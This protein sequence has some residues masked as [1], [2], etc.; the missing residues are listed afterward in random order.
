MST[1]WVDASWLD[2][3]LDEH[4]DELI[5]C[6]H[7]LHAHPELSNQ[8]VRTTALIV[9]RLARAGL[10]PRVL[11]TGTG[12]LCDLGTGDSASRDRADRC[13][14]L[15]ADIDG[16]AMD[17][18]KSVGHRSTVAGVAHGCGHDL[19]TTVVLG[20]G[21][22]LAHHLDRGAASGRVRLIFEPSEEMLPGG[23]HDVIAEGG[24]DD[25]DAI[26]GFHADPRID[27][28][29]IGL[30]VGA[31]TSAADDLEV[32]LHGPGGHTARPHLTVDLVALAGRIAAEL[33]ALVASRAE[34]SVVFGAIRAGEAPNVVPTTAVLRGSVRTPEVDTWDR[35]EA[36]VRAALHELI[37][38]PRATC[39]VAYRRGVP[40][41][42]NTAAET[43]LMAE[44]VEAVLGADHLVEPPRS[45]GG[46]TFAWYQQRVGGCYARL[47]VHDPAD[48]VHLDLHSGAFDVDDR[49]I[50]TGIRVLVTTALAAL[51]RVDV[52]G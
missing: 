43:A 29:T 5:A 34:L 8:E 6:R 12:V 31:L 23:A 17:D 15:R 44:A 52:E 26:F 50:E 21:L 14:A 20:A 32:T 4:L 9:E 19:H 13:V 22:A 27:V 7:H 18:T 33:P 10:G 38:D 48:P 2:D 28:G 35:A 47:G 42:V 11:R 40:P 16:L 51:R 36:V 25:V 37:D 45:A 41:V 24:L 30:R 46:D 3:F 49:A 39:E 1:S